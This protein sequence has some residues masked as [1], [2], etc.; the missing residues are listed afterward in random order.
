[1]KRLPLLV[2][3]LLLALFIGA[4]GSTYNGGTYGVVAKTYRWAPAERGA[5]STPPV[6]SCDAVCAA[7]WQRVN[8]SANEPSQ[9]A[10]RA[11]TG[12]TAPAWPDWSVDYSDSYEK[13]FSL[14][15]AAGK[16]AYFEVKARDA[17]GN[18][19]LVCSDSFIWA[20]D[21]SCP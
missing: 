1:M 12:R 13:Y 14:T 16:E 2:V 6:V 3:M 7:S 4:S 18:E 19:S 8:A 21:A 5:D 20:F 10:A 17:A 9:W 11:W 15:P